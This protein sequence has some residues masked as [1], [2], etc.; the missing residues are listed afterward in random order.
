MLWTAAVYEL[1]VQ[2][3]LRSFAAAALCVGPGPQTLGDPVLVGYIKKPL[4]HVYSPFPH[5]SHTPS[6]PRE[7]KR[8]LSACSLS[9]HRSSSSLIHEVLCSKPRSGADNRSS[10]SMDRRRDDARSMARGDDPGTAMLLVGVPWLDMRGAIMAA[11][12]ACPTPDKTC[13][14]KESRSN[15]SSNNP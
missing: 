11:A 1:H 9:A 2:C 15:K 6:P 13:C 8:A 4:L 10:P 7:D 5:P 14:S 12:C 3:L